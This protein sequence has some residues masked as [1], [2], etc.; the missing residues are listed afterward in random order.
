MKFMKAILAG[1]FILSASAFTGVLP[2]VAAA[3]PGK[4]DSMGC[5]Y[6]RNY[7]N[8]HC[9]EGPLA[10]QTFQSRAQAI[11]HWNRARHQEE[12]KKKKK[13]SEDNDDGGGGGL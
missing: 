11:R 6:D 2:G 9:H 13:E 1:T 10:G 8:Y 5:H 12:E 7:R 4:L 3:H